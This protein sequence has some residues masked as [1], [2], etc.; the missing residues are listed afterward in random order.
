MKLNRRKFFAFS[1]AA[2]TAENLRA[3]NAPVNSNAPKFSPLQNVN[4]Q[5]NQPGKLSSADIKD[6]AAAVGTSSTG[7]A[8]VAAAV[9][10]LAA[11]AGNA[12]ATLNVIADLAA[13]NAQTIEIPANI[14]VKIAPS[15]RFVVPPGKT[16]K[17]SGALEA[18]YAPLV[19]GGGQL[20]LT[21]AK[22]PVLRPEWFYSGAGSY[23]AA[24]NEAAR[25]A[26]FAKG[27]T[28]EFAPNKTYE[29]AEPINVSRFTR[30]RFKGYAAIGGQPTIRYTG[31]AAPA[32]DARGSAGIILDQ[33]HVEYSNPNFKGILIDLN[34]QPGVAGDTMWF[35]AIDSVFTGRTA[36]GESLATAHAFICASRAIITTVERCRFHGAQRGIKGVET[37]DYYSNVFVINNNT[38]NRCYRSISSPGSNYS[39][40][41]NTFEPYEYGRACALDCEFPGYYPHALVFANNYVG[42]LFGQ[43][44]P[45]VMIRQ[46]HGVSV[47][48]NWFAFEESPK[49]QEAVLIENCWGV[50][51]AGNDGGGMRFGVRF[52][53]GN[54]SVSAAGNLWTAREAAYAGLE[55]VTEA[56]LLDYQFGDTN[57][58]RVGNFVKGGTEHHE[59]FRQIGKM[60]IRGKVRIAEGNF[61]PE[62]VVIG[63][64][65]AKAN[66][67][68][69]NALSV[70]NGT[71]GLTM[72]VAGEKGHF[73][74]ANNQNDVGL[75]ALNASK[76]LNLLVGN[77]YLSITANAV[78]TAQDIEITDATK[79]I[80]VRS[81]NGT[82]FRKTINDAGEWVTTRL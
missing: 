82:R 80:I 14:T 3:Q 44:E 23:S 75:L 61:S 10:G 35:T 42:D 71:N 40:T 34:W 62:L 54:H 37:P 79:G 73:A 64:E 69:T 13:G 63:N 22:T 49:A 43:T 19:A 16:V 67:A 41:N 39:I 52:T 2:A 48:G 9:R 6:F 81:P 70:R 53:G 33:M 11:V 5:T 77:N 78:K 46:S 25:Q 30:V 26:H 24:I 28:I 50:R 51:I 56:N 1:V 17:I 76:A 7:F 55:T 45:P 18:G 58:D 15:G 36:K 72:F 38:F 21:E 4:A 12:P 8:D 27:Q 57:F 31:T 66:A 60:E 59:L 47:T 29:C 32:I 74:D 68:D 20:D 65:D